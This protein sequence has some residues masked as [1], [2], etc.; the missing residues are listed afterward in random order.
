MNKSAALFISVILLTQIASYSFNEIQS[1]FDQDSSLQDDSNWEVSGRNNSTGNN[2]GGN[3][4]GGNN[5]GGNNTGGN[6]TGGNNTGGNNTGGNNTGGNNTG[7]NNT[8]GNNTGGNNTGGNNTGGNQTSPCGTNLSYTT[9]YSS[10]SSMVMENQSFSTS[11][12]VNC[13]ILNATMMLDYWIYDSNNYTVFSGNQSWNGTANSSLLVPSVSGLTAGYYT[14]H[15][16]LY[17]NGVFAD[18]D[19]ASFMVYANNSGGGN[20]TGGNNTGGNNTGGNNTG[21]NN[22]SHCL[23]LGNFS[24]S[25]TYYVT[26]D[27]I[28]T[29]SFAINY[30]GINSSAD[31]SGVSGLYNY[32]NWW[33]MIGANGTY[34]YT[35]QLVF[36]SSVLNG[37][38][39][40]L[41]FE[42]AILNC[43]TNGTWHDCPDSN[44]STLSYEFQYTT[45]PTT[46]IIYSAGLNSGNDRISVLYKS[47]NYSGYVNWT[48]D[49]SNG[50]S[51]ASSYANSYFRTTYIYPSTYGEIQICGSISG[52]ITC[53][54]VTRNVRPLYG[55][56]DYPSNNS[57]TSASSIYISYFAEN[58]TTGVLELNN[59]TF[60]YLQST[61]SNNGSNSS[62]ITFVNLP[63]GW[64]TICLKLTGDNN[65]TLSEC[66]QVYRETPVQRLIIESATI[67]TS[68]D[69]ITLRY[70]SENYSGYVNWTYNSSNGTS[71]SSSY[72]NSYSRLT[73]IYPGTFGTIEICG[74]INNYSSDCVNVIRNVRIVEGFI[75][76]GV[77]NTSSNRVDFVYFAN[78]HTNGSVSLDG[79]T[80]KSL[81]S[82]FDSTSN[83]SNSYHYGY[84]FIPY[85]FSTI[86]LELVGEDGTQLSDCI[87]VERYAPP[88]SV[89]ITYPATGV[90]F[91]GQYLSLS[92]ALENSSSHH[93]T[94]DG[95]SVYTNSSNSSMVQIDVGFG[96]HE[97]CVV[98][99]DF[100][101]QMASDCVTVNMFDP[102]ADS[103]SDGVIDTSDLCPNTPAN[104]SVN[105]NGCSTSQLDTDSDGV[106]DNLDIC[107]N[108]QMGSSVDTNG[109]ASYQR[110][111][112]GDGVMD[113]LDTCPSTLVNSIVDAYGCSNSQTD[114]DNDGVMDNLDLC[115]NTFVGSQ[116][117]T[118][119]CAPSQLDSD[120]DG[121]V[122]SFDQCPST[123][124]G[125]VVDST[126]CAPS[127]NGNNNGS[128][129]G[130]STSDDS[131][132]GGLPS[133]GIVG[134]LAAI[135]VSFVAVIRR[136][137]E[138]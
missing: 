111:T 77:N 32:T 100:A 131:D 57:T 34:N 108:T 7:G 49:S 27:L 13:E 46:L 98:S 107:P 126:G 110:D 124:A 58:Y 75:N 37:T 123:A 60:Y 101:N 22:D 122:D 78:N 53:V 94:V 51:S 8:S 82:N 4:T 23:T 70:H 62:N 56:I 138:E 80:F 112:D 15:A 54:N 36:N 117:N 41:D 96:T 136:E 63:L 17:V 73:Y 76:S 121:V 128:S 93:F 50:T 44:N 74:T 97:V 125:T 135:A 119:G 69:Y 67:S 83:L 130:N 90:S 42:A 64:S 29:C 134:T 59:Q 102:N 24:M 92:Y 68:N 103:D 127:T 106:T 87:T 65:T 38:N 71:T 9:V 20:N 66:I 116:V 28:N 105:N 30:P 88:H 132:S 14:F 114:S 133:I 109:C 91:T 129:S 11:M 12:Y 43:G 120:S 72:T 81:G 5:S 40:T 52:D 10:V 79:V 118:D 113:N 115:P 47:L 99:N 26:I 31:N 19:A 21:L 3:N 45:P 84:R 89:S 25:S 2:T 35:A 137:Q 86:C 39:V 16:D 61:N 33:Y 95:T 6:N 104:E 85:G 48:Y 18:S 1:D 55:E